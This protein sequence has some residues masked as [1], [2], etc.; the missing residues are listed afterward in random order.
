MSKPVRVEYLTVNE[1]REQNGLPPLSEK[2]WPCMCPRI[3]TFCS[4]EGHTQHAPRCI[5]YAKEHRISPPPPPQYG[6]WIAHPTREDILRYHRH[7]ID[8]R[9]DQ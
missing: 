9:L 3:E 1:M 4:P 5:H 7:E 2:E 6:D 8:E